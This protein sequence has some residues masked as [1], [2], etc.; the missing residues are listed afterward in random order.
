MALDPNDSSN[1]ICFI[2]HF[3]A[4]AFPFAPPFF[5]LSFSASSISIKSFIMPCKASFR[6]H[7]NRT[8][9]VVMVDLPAC[10]EKVSRS[11]ATFSICNQT[12]SVN[13]PMNW[14]VGAVLSDCEAERRLHSSV[15]MRA[16]EN[17]RDDLSRW[18]AVSRNLNIAG[19]RM[20]TSASGS[21]SS[22]ACEEDMMSP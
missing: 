16:I 15:Q 5:G 6:R 12:I 13:A 2:N 20:R 1:I 11:T 8:S 10:R 3:F 19:R 18:K 17:Q 14:G 22:A 9:S 21:S 4:F 7:I